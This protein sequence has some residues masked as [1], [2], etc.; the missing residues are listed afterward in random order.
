MMSPEEVEELDKKKQWV[1]LQLATVCVVAPSYLCP[2]PRLQ[3]AD[4]HIGPH[5]L[6]SGAPIFS[7]SSFQ[8]HSLYQWGRDFFLGAFPTS[9]TNSQVLGSV[10]RW[11][12]RS[13]VS[14][15]LSEHPSLREYP[16]YICLYGTFLHGEVYTWKRS[17]IQ[18]GV[19]LSSHVVCCWLASFQRYLQSA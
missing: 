15:R 17:R 6:H 7:W 16:L 10:T 14:K 9:T 4:G 13:W 8:Q 19:F 11:K 18:G 3:H 1:V 2:T 5:V 12:N